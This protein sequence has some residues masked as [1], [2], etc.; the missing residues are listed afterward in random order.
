MDPPFSILVHPA[1]RYLEEHTQVPYTLDRETR[2]PLVKAPALSWMSIAT[3][4]G[5]LFV[6]V[7]T[8]RF[9]LN[10]E[11]FLATEWESWYRVGAGMPSVVETIRF[12]V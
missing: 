3:N 11:A 5:G 4:R 8:P 9:K 7:P 12:S 6:D 10:S 2:N 1:W